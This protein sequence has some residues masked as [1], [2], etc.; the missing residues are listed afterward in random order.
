MLIIIVKKFYYLQK[1]AQSANSRSKK[2]EPSESARSTIKRLDEI[3]LIYHDPPGN[4]KLKLKN[5][6]S[7]FTKN[8]EKTIAVLD[9]ILLLLLII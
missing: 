5:L 4:G 3:S 6:H 7:I 2:E 9:A 8:P 1:N